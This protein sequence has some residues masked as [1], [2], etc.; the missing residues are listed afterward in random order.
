MRHYP[1][2][3]KSAP[4]G[5]GGQALILGLFFLAAGSAVLYFMFNTGQVVR[6]KTTLTNSADAAAYSGGALQARALN[7]LSYTNR[8][9]VANTV[10]I[11]QIT[12][13]MSWNAYVKQLAHANL[14]AT[15]DPAELCLRFCVT[16]DGQTNLIAIYAGNTVARAY[17][18]D[19]LAE[20]AS[21]LAPAFDK[22]GNSAIYASDEAAIR[23]LLMPAATTMWAAIPVARD[24][25]VKEVASE[26]YE[27]Y[28]DADAIVALV[29][30]DSWLT[31]NGGGPAV[32]LYSDDART[33][34]ADLAQAA[35]DEDG[36]VSGRDW[37]REALIPLCIGINGIKFDDFRRGGGTHLREL[38]EWEAVDTASW[39]QAYMSKGKCKYREKVTAFG[40]ASAGGGTS[41]DSDDDQFSRANDNPGAFDQSSNSAF[42][43]D[44]TGIPSFYELNEAVLNEENP[45]LK[46]GVHLVREAD[47]FRTTNARA[48]NQLDADA[49]INVYGSP[50]E[51]DMVAVSA[52]ELVFDRPRDEN[53]EQD[54]EEL[55]SLFNPFWHVRLTQASEATV[56]AAQGLQ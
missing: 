51:R 24:E 15:P 4:R 43:Y 40:T 49:R 19:V 44:Y 48:Q 41:V 56:L 2:S 3:T 34:F 28:G 47:Q 9:E 1:L 54:R 45:E 20:Y 14:E 35:A 46:F 12:A 33:R 13:L 8:A 32:E 55:A 11:A 39:H 52:A 50:D 31:H 30:D 18:V 17:G 38:E 16:A 25:L 21:V 37:D 29:T 23:A 53:G 36:F 5:Q 42:S 22:A 27:H 7:F 6:E 26:N 10:A